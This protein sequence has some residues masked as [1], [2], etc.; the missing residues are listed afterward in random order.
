[1]TTTAYWTPARNVLA[2]RLD[3]LVGDLFGDA[4]LDAPGESV[5]RANWTPAVDIRETKEAVQ[6]DIEL[7]GLSRED[8]SVSVENNVL[9]VSGE[10][11][12]EKLGEDGA[13]R[14]VERSYGKFHRAFT[15]PNDVERT[16]VAAKFQDGVLSISLPKAEETK[17]RT[18][19]IQ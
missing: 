2:H 15:L 19:S 13:F 11:K 16:N 4:N 8:V 1:M 5:D 17:P 9:T 6:L 3:R 18:I 14:R 7:A 10:R 12:I